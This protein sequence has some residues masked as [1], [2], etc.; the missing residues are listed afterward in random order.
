MCVSILQHRMRCSTWGGLLGSMIETFKLQKKSTR[1]LILMDQI[2]PGCSAL[3]DTGARISMWTKSEQM[4]LRL[5]SVRLLKEGIGFSGF[6]GRTDGNLYEMDLPF[7]SL[8]Y[9]K[10]RII[11]HQDDRIPGFFLLSASMFEGMV[12]T[13]DREQNRF[14]L[15]TRNNQV[16]LLQREVNQDGELIILTQ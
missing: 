11:Q 10:V 5:P 13:V 6:G 14:L 12:Y 4:L 3:L 8:I 7:G 9:P 1:P 16:C 15:D 2:F